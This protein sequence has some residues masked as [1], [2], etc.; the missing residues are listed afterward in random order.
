MGLSHFEDDGNDYVVVACSSEIAALEGLED[1]IAEKVLGEKSKD[2]ELRMDTI[3][4]HHNK[5]CLLLVL[6]SAWNNDI[7]EEVISH[8]KGYIAGFE[9]GL[10]SM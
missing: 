10:N 5:T 3:R 9:A 2:W 4:I 6:A 7:G 8:C 1:F